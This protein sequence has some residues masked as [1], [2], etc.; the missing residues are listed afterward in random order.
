M[1]PYCI[2]SLLRN[3]SNFEVKKRE[4]TVLLF[5][6]KNI[7]EEVYKQPSTNGKALVVLFID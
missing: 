7:R 4:Q 3:N 1:S 5:A 6:K 2:S